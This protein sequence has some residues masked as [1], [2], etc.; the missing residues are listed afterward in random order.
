MSVIANRGLAVIPDGSSLTAPFPH[1]GLPI[2]PWRDPQTVSPLERSAYIQ[3][4]ERVCLENPQSVELRT[5][6]GMAYAMD[7]QVYKSM[8]VLEAATAMDPDHFWAQ[9]KY[10]ELHYRLRA[11]P[12]AERETLKAVDLARNPWEL[13]VARKQLQE[14]RRLLREGTRTIAW[15]KPLITPALVLLAMFALLFVTRFWR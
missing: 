2:V 7:Y 15:N 14:I 4:L 10:A 9:L 6:L 8:D 3:L 12:A 11:L 13:N 5:F 1:E